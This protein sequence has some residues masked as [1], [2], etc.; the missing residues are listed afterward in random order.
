MD[1]PRQL[2]PILLAVTPIVSAVVLSFLMPLDPQPFMVQMALIAVVTMGLVFGYHA[3]KLKDEEVLLENEE[4]R[5]SL[6]I[7]AINYAAL[8]KTKNKRAEA[9]DTSA[10]HIPPKV[11]AR[12]T[13]KAQVITEQIVTHPQPLIDEDAGKA[14]KKAKK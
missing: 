14:P 5:E 1:L 9:V 8:S 4:L 7:G 3:G 2:K 12:P 6:R 11:A 13:R 10:G